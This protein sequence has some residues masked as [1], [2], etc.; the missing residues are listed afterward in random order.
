[1]QSHEMALNEE[2]TFQTYKR[3]RK[4]VKAV[5]KLTFRK[6]LFQLVFHFLVYVFVF[7]QVVFIA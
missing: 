2:K 4:I 1:M 7:P 6:N 3:K 5:Y